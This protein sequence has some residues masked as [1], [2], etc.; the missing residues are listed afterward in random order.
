MQPPAYGKEKNY[1]AR[2]IFKE[3]VANN[4]QP[5][6]IDINYKIDSNTSPEQKKNP[7]GREQLIRLNFFKNHMYIYIYIYI[8]IYLRVV[9][10]FLA[11]PKKRTHS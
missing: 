10:K 2:K 6:K 1:F 7:K 11:S 9:Q 4:S 8:Y 3:I 5:S